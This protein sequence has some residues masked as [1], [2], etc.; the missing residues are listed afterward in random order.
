MLCTKCVKSSSEYQFK[1]SLK[2]EN[3]LRF[4]SKSRSESRGVFFMLEVKFMNLFLK[5]WGGGYR[6]TWE[7]GQMSEIVNQIYSIHCEL[8]LFFFEFKS[9]LGFNFLS[10]EKKCQKGKVPKNWQIF[11]VFLVPVE[12]VNVWMQHFFLWVFEDCSQWCFG[13]TAYCHNVM[14]IYFYSGIWFIQFS[15][16]MAI[17][18]YALR[19]AN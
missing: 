15:H 19:L 2:M 8:L 3:N 6:L 16:N 12:A 10:F 9:E 7:L 5:V 11:H 1:F 14:Y 4:S 18:F 17:F 13:F